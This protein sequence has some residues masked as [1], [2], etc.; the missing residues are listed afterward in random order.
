M[1]R[2]KKQNAGEE[3]EFVPEMDK[4]KERS[5]RKA[6]PFFR[7]SVQNSSLL[8]KRSMVSQ[9]NI[10]ITKFKQK[11]YPPLPEFPDTDFFDPWFISDVGVLIKESQLKGLMKIQQP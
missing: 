2:I 3:A 11:S 10:S 9:K 1:V 6:S 5:P 8:S 7:N 4:S